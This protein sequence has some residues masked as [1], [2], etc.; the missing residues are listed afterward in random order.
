MQNVEQTFMSQYA[1]SATMMSLIDSM[2]QFLSIDADLD[3][4]YLAVWDI[5][6]DGATLNS[7]GLDVWGRIVGVSRN[8]NI[9]ADV[10]NPGGYS[11]TAGTYV[12]SDSDFRTLILIKALANITSCTAPSLNT[13]LSRLFAS[14]GRC[15]VKDTGNMTMTFTFEFYLLPYEYAIVAISGVIPHPAGVLVN[16]EQISGDVFGFEN[17]GLQPFDQGTFFPG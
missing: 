9:P 1:N 17:S 8:L 2:N 10:V 13:L 14:R 5:L 16:I 12:L 4:F 6:K 7:Y 15:Y 3:A 11:F